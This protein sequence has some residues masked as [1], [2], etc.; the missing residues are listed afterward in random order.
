[1]YIPGS[2]ILA[3]FIQ[4]T[5]DEYYLKLQDMYSFHVVLSHTPSE[6]DPAVETKVA[7]DFEY[8]IGST[9]KDDEDEMLYQTTRVCD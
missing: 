3:I 7:C 5:I 8:L 4:V 2:N 1:V 6:I 9:Q